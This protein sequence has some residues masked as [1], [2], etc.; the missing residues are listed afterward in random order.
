MRSYSLRLSRREYLGFRVS[1]FRFQVKTSDLPVGRATAPNADL[2]CGNLLPLFYVATCRDAIRA[3]P[4]RRIPKRRQVAAL[5]NTEARRENAGGRD[6]LLHRP[7]VKANLFATGER[8]RHQLSN[9]VEH[10]FELAIV[11]AF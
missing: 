10:N 11:L 4:T 1:S 3:A 8:R 5:R 9:R 6:L 2:E 7:G